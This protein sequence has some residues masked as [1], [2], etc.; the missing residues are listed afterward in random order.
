[1][2]SRRTT[3]RGKTAALLFLLLVLAT[4]LTACTFEVQPVEDFTTADGYFSVT[5]P[6]S[7]EV[8][9]EE[10]SDGMTAVF[11]G[12]NEDLI[13]LDVVPAGDAGVA[14]MLMPNFVPGPTGEAVPVT[15]EEMADFMHASASSEQAGVTEVQ[16]ETL[17]DGKEAF[18]F[19]APSPEADMTIHVF[20][21]A[22]GVLAVA[23]VITASGETSSSVQAEA[24]NIL[25]NL[26]VTGDA[27]EFGNRARA[28]MGLGE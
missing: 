19:T 25:N 11:I 13:D 4:V 16:P 3:P 15:A 5:F 23:A 9:E 28:V 27:I 12:T 14:L 2:P 18:T 1:M 26:R 24:L 10:S 20:A 7:W 8:L 21:P 6:A 22:E 17:A